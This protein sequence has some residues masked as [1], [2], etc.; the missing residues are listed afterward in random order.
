MA[1]S[2]TVAPLAFAVASPAADVSSR[3]VSIIP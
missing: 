2:L 3:L 1:R